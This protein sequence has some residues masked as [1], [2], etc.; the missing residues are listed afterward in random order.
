MKSVKQTIIGLLTAAAPA[1]FAAK[2]IATLS[3]VGP[4][5]IS[6]TEMS[7]VSTVFWPFANLDE[8]RTLGSRAV[9]ILPDRSRITLSSHS[10]ARIESD[11]VR[12]RLTVLSGSGN[13]DLVSP[14]SATIVVGSRIVSASATQGKFEGS[15]DGGSRRNNNQDNQDDSEEKHKKHKHPSP[16]R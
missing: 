3:S 11:G 9:L 16:D 2:P 5:F 13:Y 12:T 4:V 8:I 1:A 15:E 14:S 7:A 10:K 6:G